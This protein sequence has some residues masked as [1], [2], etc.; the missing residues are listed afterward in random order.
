MREL[1]AGTRVITAGTLRGLLVVDRQ[2]A[3][4]VDARTLMDVQS[5]VTPAAGGAVVVLDMRIT[6]RVR[7]K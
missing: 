7:V 1:P 5:E 2:R 4:I 3:W 6:Q